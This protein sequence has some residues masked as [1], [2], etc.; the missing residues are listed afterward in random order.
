MSLEETLSKIDQRQAIVGVIGLGYVGL[1][2]ACMFASVGFRV[3]GVD[4]K[5]DRVAKINSG[6]SP[7][8][9]EEP[10]LATFLAEVV[11]SGRLRATS[12]Y[13]ELA[14]ADIVLIDVETPVDA[15]H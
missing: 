13:A 14:E 15:E 6:R 10:G 2:V 3:I 7:I 1:P 8:E 5:D 11:G 4:V 9:G 12:S